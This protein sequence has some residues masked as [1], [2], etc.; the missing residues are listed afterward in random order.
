[1]R[2]GKMMSINLM[3]EVV[4]IAESVEGLLKFTYDIPDNHA[5]GKI[6]V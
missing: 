4:N 2:N 6:A 1:M 3:Q 5:S